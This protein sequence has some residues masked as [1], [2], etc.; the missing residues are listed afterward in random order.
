M[1]VRVCCVLGCVLVGGLNGAASAGTSTAAAERCRGGVGLG[2]GAEPSWSPDGKWIAFIRHGAVWSISADG[3]R[4]TCITHPGRNQADGSPTWD[5]NGS[6]IV[7]ARFTSLGTRGASSQLYV[8]GS[9]GAGLR[10]LS[11]RIPG[12][13]VDPKWFPG[14]EIVFSSKCKLGFVAGDG[15]KLRLVR[16]PGIA[17]VWTPTWSWK[18][19][20][21]AFASTALPSNAPSPPPSIWTVNRAGQDLRR[22]TVGHSDRDPDFSPDGRQLAMSRDCRIAV[23]DLK[24]QTV[25]FLTSRALA[26]LYCARSPE[27]SPS[28]KSMVYSVGDSVYTMRPDGSHKRRIAGPS[29]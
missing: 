9:E 21:I 20:L 10:R 23:L 12:P 17:C 14:W 5:S 27:W 1:I 16:V 29:G 3:N 4:L 15:T 26:N 22:L 2:S 24:K 13:S 19:S 25:E 6:R 18:R 11:V 7:F 28:G 8:I